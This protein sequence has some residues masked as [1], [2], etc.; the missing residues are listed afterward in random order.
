MLEKSFTIEPALFVVLLNVECF[1]LLQY[2]L[3]LFFMLLKVINSHTVAHTA[4]TGGIGEQIIILRYNARFFF[5]LGFQLL[6]DA[7]RRIA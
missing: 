2:M 3:N 4:V 7:P 6:V 1:D 5:G